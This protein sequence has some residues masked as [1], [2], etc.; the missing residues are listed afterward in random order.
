MESNDVQVVDER[1]DALNMLGKEAFFAKRRGDIKKDRLFA[2]AIRALKK[3]MGIL[4]DDI[5]EQNTDIIE[6]EAMEV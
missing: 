1:Q 2:I 3:D 4:E 5:V 6:A